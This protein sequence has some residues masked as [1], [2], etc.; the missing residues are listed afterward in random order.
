[1]SSRIFVSKREDVTGGLRKS[2]NK[3]LHLLLTRYYLNDKMK[4][5]EMGG[6]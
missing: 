3:E 6:I 1:V 5:D 2:H 4:E